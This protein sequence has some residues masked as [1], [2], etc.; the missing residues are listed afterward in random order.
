MDKLPST[1]TNSDLWANTLAPQENDE[2]AAARERLR[3]AFTTCRQSAGLLTDEI[4][5]DLPQLTL[6]NLTHIDALWETAGTILGPNYDIT[7]A[8]GFVLGVAFLFHDLGMA[9]PT[10]DGGI[11]ALKADSRW[12]DLVTYEYQTSLERE[13]SA[14]E[15][16]NP[17]E[18]IYNRVLLSLLQQIHAA[19]AERL[20]FTALSSEKGND[21]IYLIDDLEVRQ[22]FGR[23]IGQVAHSHWWDISKLDQ[24]FQRTVGAAHWCP[25]DWT[26]DPLKVACILRCADAAQ[27]D[28]RRAPIYLKASTELPDTSADHWTFQEKFNKPYLEEDALVFTTNRAFNISEA[29]A[30]WLCLET[31][32]MVDKEL[33]SVDALF[34]DKGAPRFAA[35]RVAGIEDPERL[36]SYVQTDGWL[37]IN[38]TIHV[39]DLPRAIKSVGGEEM[40]GKHPE[41]ALR[42]LIQNASDAVCARRIYERRQADYGEIRVSLTQSSNSSHWLEVEDN[43]V[44]MSQFVLTNFLLDFGRSFWG[45]FE[46]QREFPGL[47]SSGIKQ[48]G[49]YGIGFFSVFMLAE[50]VQVITRRSDSAAKDTLVLEFSRG[51][52]GRPILREANNSEQL[53]D[54][55]TKVRLQLQVDPS[56]SEGLLYD[57]YRKAPRK[58][59]DICIELCPALEVDLFVEEDGVSQQVIR[60]GDWQT[61]DAFEFL[62]R[63]PVLDSERNFSHEDVDVFRRKAADNLRCLRDRSGNI[64]GRALVT[65]GFAGHIEPY[66]DLSGIVTIGGL[67]SCTLSGIAG[68]L[69]G[70]PLRASRDVAK[71][72]VETDELKRWAQEQSTLVPSLWEEEK[73]QAACAQYIRLCGGDTENLPICLN[74]GNWYS[75][76]QI[77]SRKD[78]PHQVVLVDHFSIDYNFEHV[79]DYTLND[80]VFVTQVGGIPGLLQSRVRWTEVHWPQDTNTNF[81]LGSGSPNLTLGGAVLESIAQAWDL[82][83]KTIVQ[84]NDLEREPKVAIG[85]TGNGRVL[86]ERAIVVTKPNL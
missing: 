15:I 72:I 25:R 4:R 73:T 43:G 59:S 67:K 78:L 64:I 86:K 50:H 68:V 82:N 27:V 31:L 38:A 84:N 9:L 55:G 46:M 5:R 40:Y 51:L 29:S 52:K 47:L 54:G 6:H 60:G 22:A 19:N 42:E 3:A 1:I 28:A 85:V 81:F 32:R 35:K 23:V 2:S 34:A 49:K 7:P 39:T 63:I 30:W 44:G 66:I 76:T 77:R 26:I 21:S 18:E 45:S 24:Q 17:E 56:L 11:E 83:I 10:V 16:S 12:K 53:I 69:V 57:S 65:V 74:K 79:E 37:P 14:E 75:A 36:V 80:N 13:P 48:I 33:G 20:A 8:E 58:L 61:L 41:V 62:K 71:P 70:M